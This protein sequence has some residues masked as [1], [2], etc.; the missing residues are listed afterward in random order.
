MSYLEGFPLAVRDKDLEPVVLKVV[1]VRAVGEAHLAGKVEDA[2]E[3]GEALVDV[4]HQAVQDA[5]PL[6]LQLLHALG[7]LSHFPRTPVF[8]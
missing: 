7:L 4:L 3:A 6:C 5:Q 1:V 8:L 2:E